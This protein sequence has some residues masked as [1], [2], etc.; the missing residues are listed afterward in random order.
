LEAL[1][2]EV[3]ALR[4]GLDG[5]RKPVKGLE[6]E[7]QALKGKGGFG[8]QPMAIDFGFPVLRGADAAPQDPSYFAG[9]SG[10]AEGL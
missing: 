1:R 9:A 6:D 10:R 5:T 2:L 3:E 4:K 8:P 7:V